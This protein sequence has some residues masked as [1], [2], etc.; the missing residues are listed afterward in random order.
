[1]SAHT[2]HVYFLRRTSGE[3]PV[4]IGCSF[5]PEDRLATFMAWSPY[6]LEI[7]ARI[8][9][10]MKLEGRFHTLL[11]ADWSH[12]EWF[13]PSD[14]VL[15]VVSDVAAGMFDFSTLPPKIIRPPAQ[16]DSRRE[17]WTEGRKLEAR[18]HRLRYGAGIDEP[19]DVKFAAEHFDSLEAGARDAAR[20]LILAH[21]ADPLRRGVLLTY[22]WA[23]EAFAKWATRKRLPALKVVRAA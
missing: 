4:K 3:G 6:P 11:R 23:R 13:F 16:Y 12:G 20:D 1:M 22:P 14:H 19:Q 10:D 17:P 5:E 8:P 18:L 15:R 7:A 2:K 21:L 9:G